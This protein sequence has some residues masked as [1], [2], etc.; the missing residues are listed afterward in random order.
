MVT[1]PCRNCEMRKIPKTCEK[2]CKLWLEYKEQHS[3]E[4]IELQMQRRTNRMISDNI[5]RNY[6]K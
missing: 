3:K 2:D 6:D 4:L 5:W 1:A